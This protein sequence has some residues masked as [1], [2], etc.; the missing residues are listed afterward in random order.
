MSD[1]KEKQVT[2][3]CEDS[4]CWVSEWT[5]TVGVRGGEDTINSPKC[6][7]CGRKGEKVDKE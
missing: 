3:V 4:G 2:L 5:S 6:P 7:G 1:K